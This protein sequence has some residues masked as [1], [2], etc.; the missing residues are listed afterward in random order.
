VEI[1][2][3]GLTGQAGVEGWVDISTLVVKWSETRLWDKAP[4][5]GPCFGALFRTTSK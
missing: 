2:Q 5:H 4:K 3:G 1:D